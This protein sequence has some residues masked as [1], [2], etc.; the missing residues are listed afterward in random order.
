MFIVPAVLL[1][2]GGAPPPAGAAGGDVVIEGPLERLQAGERAVYSLSWLGIAVGRSEAVVKEIVPIRGRPCYHIIVKNRS[3]AF[4]DLIFKVRDEYHSWLDVRDL[5]TLRFE[6]TVLEGRYRADEEIDFDHAAGTARYHSR[7]NGSRKTFSFVPGAV[8][9]ISAVYKYRFVPLVVG[10]ETRM[11][12]TWDE[13]NHDLRIRAEKTGW[14][15][16]RLLGKTG[17]VRLKPYVSKT[18]DPNIKSSRVTLW[19]TTDSRRIPI[20][21]KTRVPI[22]TSV[23][24]ILVEYQPGTQ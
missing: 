20:L 7:T 3:N 13:K 4:L 8:D 5:K 2:L 23:N 17:A 18:R 6:K 19:M 10:G 15:Q 12:L 16:N 22:A 1:C 24:A 11:P 9:S 21:M 14:R